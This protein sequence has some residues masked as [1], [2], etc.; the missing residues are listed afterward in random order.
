MSE[1]LTLV[2]TL[3]DPQNQWLYSATI[4]RGNANDFRINEYKK[5]T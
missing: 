2:K 3:T 1:K 4:L 5:H